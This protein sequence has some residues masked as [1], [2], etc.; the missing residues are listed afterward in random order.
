MTLRNIDFIF[1]IF[2]SGR[3]LTD[4]PERCAPDV[5]W[6]TTSTEEKNKCRMLSIAGRTHGI[7]PNIMCPV[8]AANVT[9]CIKYVN[10]SDADIAVI[11]TNEGFVA[12]R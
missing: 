12:R 2:T 6:C 11:S 9:E 1:L 4:E 7:V 10:Q 3:S 8:S 5:K